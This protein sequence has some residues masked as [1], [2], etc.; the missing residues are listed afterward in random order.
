MP[1]VARH[2]C[3]CSPGALPWNGRRTRSN[4]APDFLEAFR[5]RAVGERD[6]VGPVHVNIAVQIADHVRDARGLPDVA[7]VDD[8]H[9]LVGSSD[10]I[11]RFGVAMEQLAGVQ[12]RAGGEFQCQDCAVRRLDKTPDPAPVVGAHPQFHDRQ[13]RRRFECDGQ[14]A[15]ESEWEGLECASEVQ[16]TQLQLS[17]FSSQTSALRLQLPAS[18]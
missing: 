6:D 12:H 17:D 13:V 2:Q 5:Q 7:R 16:C 3:E 8:E 9:V 1:P 15:R 4:G 18:S 14:A 10:D 11:G